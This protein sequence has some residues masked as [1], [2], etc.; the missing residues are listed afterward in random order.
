MASTG[1][2]GFCVITSE[3]GVAAG[4]R[5]IEA[6]TG[7]AAEEV[8]KEEKALI[9]QLSDLLKNPRDLV[10]AV[11]NQQEEL[12]STKKQLESTE[13][14]LAG[15]IKSELSSRTTVINQIQFVGEVVEVSNSEMLKKLCN[16]LSTTI[17]N[18]LVVLGA[19]V[20]AKPFVAIGIADSLVT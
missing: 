12:Q 9:K 10:K 19:V 3:S 7:F 2:L 14:K 11:E 13:G 5:R 17:P 15:F 1:E 18:A 4:V 6:V 20:A 8:S 16:D